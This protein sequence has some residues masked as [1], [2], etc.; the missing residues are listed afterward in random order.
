MA[1]T[2]R[3]LVTG[4]AGFI[5]FH[6]A[7][8]LASD[9]H[10]VVGVDNF[11]EYYDVRLKRERAAI[12]AKFD[13][14]SMRELDIADAAAF[15]AAWRDAAPDIVIHLAAQAGVRYSIDSPQSY[16]HSNLIGTFNVLELAR[17]ARPTHL[18]AASTSSIYGA[19]TSTPF[20]ESDRAAEPLTLYAATKGSNELMAHSYAH[21]FGIPTT[22]MRFFTVYGPWGRPDM[23]LFK[24]TR[25]LFERTPIDV[26]N[27]GV[28]VRDFTYVSDLVEAVVRLMDKA[29]ALTSDMHTGEGGS[30][31]APFRT[32]NI[33]KGEPTPLMDF[34]RA[35]EDATGIEAIK[36]F[37]PMQMGDVPSTAADLALLHQLTGYVPSTPIAAGVPAFVEWYREHYRV[38]AS[39]ANF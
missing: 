6:V 27:N 33:G 35:L 4:A 23:A 39:A 31:V 34:I 13:N 29:P 12:L 16:V 10:A 7:R 20:R 2:H 15:G 9:G 25:A 36:N 32:V 8:R 38:A 26:Y 21:L 11:S 1:T 18:L 5:G 19:N 14:F 30:H 17:H 24:F 22:M 37:L 28:M 3:I